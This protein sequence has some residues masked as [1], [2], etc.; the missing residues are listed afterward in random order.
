MYGEKWLRWPVCCDA[1]TRSM[2]VRGASIYETDTGV[3]F[4]SGRSALGRWLC[5]RADR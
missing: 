3:V 1:S 5:H 4:S 2:V